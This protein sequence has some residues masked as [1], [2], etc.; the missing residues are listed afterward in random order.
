MFFDN[1]VFTGSVDRHISFVGGNKLVL[2]VK[3]SDGFGIKAN[4][5]TSRKSIKETWDLRDL[6]TI[7]N[8]NKE[9][10]WL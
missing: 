4:A 6:I 2:Q 1:L 10:D 3:L 7:Y 5:V 9:E 8:E